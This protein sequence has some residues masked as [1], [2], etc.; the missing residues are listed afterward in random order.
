MAKPEEKQVKL[1][2]KPMEKPVVSGE[3]EKPG[4]SCD[5]DMAESITSAPLMSHVDNV[6]NEAKLG[7]GFVPMF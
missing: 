1:E 2:E 3:K 5:Q 7:N 4:T 6:E